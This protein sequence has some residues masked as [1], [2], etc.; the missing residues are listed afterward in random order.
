MPTP[1]HAWLQAASQQQCQPAD[2]AFSTPQVQAVTSA[3]NEVPT[4][5]RKPGPTAWLLLQRVPLDDGH[6]PPAADAHM[7]ETDSQ[8]RADPCSSSCLLPPVASQ[9]A[10]CVCQACVFALAAPWS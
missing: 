6:N 4:T 2:T 1:L 3:G 8:V 5:S 10:S 7:A 9:C